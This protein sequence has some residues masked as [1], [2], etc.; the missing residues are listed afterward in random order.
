MVE[1]LELLSQ[2]RRSAQRLEKAFRGIFAEFRQPVDLMF[3]MWCA[4][5]C[6]HEVDQLFRA[7][8]NKIL[9]SNAGTLLAAW[10]LKMICKTENGVSHVTLSRTA[11]H[12]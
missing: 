11:V 5:I 10:R 8:A 3:V 6:V 12:V 1:N 4:Q 7:S 2:I 9:A